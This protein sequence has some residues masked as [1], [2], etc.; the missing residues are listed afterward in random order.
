MTVTMGETR[1]RSKTA[2]RDGKSKA[3]AVVLA[4]GQRVQDAASYYAINASVLKKQQDY[5]Q[6]LKFDNKADRDAAAFT[7]SS[8]AGAVSEGPSPA[9]ITEAGSSPEDVLKAS[10]LLSQYNSKFEKVI[11]GGL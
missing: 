9:H 5:Q 11:S 7:S 1:R 4:I 8:V 3:T 6:K 10:P 2:A